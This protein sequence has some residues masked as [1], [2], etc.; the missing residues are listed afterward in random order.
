[1][2]LV[3]KKTK[4]AISFESVDGRVSVTVAEAL[5][6][7]IARGRYT[8]GERIYQDDIAEKMNVSRQPVRQALLQLK[9]EGLLVEE[10]PGRLM[11]KKA[12]PEE[13]DQVF[14]LRSLIEPEA[15]RLAAVSITEDEIERLKVANA[16]MRDEPESIVTANFDFHHTLAKATRSPLLAQFVARLLYS[17]PV[18]QLDTAV[19]HRNSQDSIRVHDRLIAALSNRNANEAEAIM[20]DHINHAHN[21]RKQFI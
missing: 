18:T 17:M 13:L 2:G 3:K 14:A 21:F 6:D 9:T 20:R 8:A 7:A 4:R 19:R 5:R 16:R 10:K 12:S 11:V 1:M 15:A